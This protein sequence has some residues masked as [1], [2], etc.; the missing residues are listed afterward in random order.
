MAK[1]LW[2]VIV[3]NGK[4]CHEWIMEER[5]G[6]EKQNFTKLKKQ[7][8]HA[9]GLEAEFGGSILLLYEVAGDKSCFSG[10]LNRNNTTKKE[11]EQ[12]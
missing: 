6:F 9:P 8:L 7:E 10:Q 4:Q 12:L 5:G 11:L 1:Q 3:E 2:G